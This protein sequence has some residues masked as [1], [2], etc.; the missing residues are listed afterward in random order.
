MNWW[1]GMRRLNRPLINTVL[2]K[3]QILFIHWFTQIYGKMSLNSGLNQVCDTRWDHTSCFVEQQKY[4]RILQSQK[5]AKNVNKNSNTAIPP[6][7]TDRRLFAHAG[8][9]AFFSFLEFRKFNGK[10]FRI[11]DFFHFF[12]TSF[13]CSKYWC[14]FNN[15]FMT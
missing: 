15:M 14:F 6:I 13:F 2:N 7:S 12:L 4:V 8:S 9:N 10:K 3:P 11:L 5:P 1:V